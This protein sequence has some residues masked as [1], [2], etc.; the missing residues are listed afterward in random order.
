MA[1]K[2]EE[3]IKQSGGQDNIKYLVEKECYTYDMLKELFNT[4]KMSR[5][6]L[7]RILKYCDASIPYPNLTLENRKWLVEW[8]RVKGNYWESSFITNL[9]I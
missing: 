5:P 3:I 2:I 9:F 1:Y 6:I 4:P 7:K 8:N